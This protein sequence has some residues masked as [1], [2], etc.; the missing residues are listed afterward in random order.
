MIAEMF[1]RMEQVH[2]NLCI[3]EY[4]LIDSQAFLP[5]PYKGMSTFGLASCGC[6]Y[7][8]LLFFM[9]ILEVVLLIN[10]FTYVASYG[11]S[12]TLRE[13]HKSRTGIC[14]ISVH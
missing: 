10:L 6:Q 7:Y 12:T 14:F 13:I 5:N 9:Q 8:H 4:H 2:R 1:L 11:C 3:P